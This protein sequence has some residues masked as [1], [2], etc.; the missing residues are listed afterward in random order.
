MRAV[1]FAG[2]AGVIAGA[3]L[4]T[5]LSSRDLPVPAP[6][7]APQR[8]TAEMRPVDPIGI[9]VPPGWDP[10]FLA[11]ISTLETR[12]AE[13]AVSGNSRPAE[14]PPLAQEP[15]PRPEPEARYARDIALEQQAL[16]EHRRE[17]LDENWARAQSG[18]MRDQFAALTS[19]NQHF[20]VAD[21]DCRS[22]TCI[23][24]LVYPTP[25]E[26]LERRDDLR[27]M[28]VM[29]CHGMSS[30]LAPP[31]APGPYKSTLV[32]TCR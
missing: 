11:R 26:A 28:L 5:F 15:A 24:Q 29:G 7:P 25:D 18:S 1:F 21:V 19:I 27:Q 23:V 20:Q 8:L 9:A 14:E 22:K 13:L 31:T 32:Y 12:V 4:V 10:R 3:V 6:A 2:T 16:Q 30:A 17:A